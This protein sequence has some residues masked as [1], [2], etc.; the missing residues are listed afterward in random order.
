MRRNSLKPRKLTGTPIR[1]ARARRTAGYVLACRTR[2]ASEP[3]RDGALNIAIP[4]AAIDKTSP[5]EHLAGRTRDDDDHNERTAPAV[6]LAPVANQARFY[7]PAVSCPRIDLETIVV[8]AH[9]SAR[10]LQAPSCA[11]RAVVPEEQSGA[12]E[13]SAHAR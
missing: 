9:E 5:Q 6:A 10:A 3:R 7:L 12:S 2:L 8:R 4:P 11:D 13:Q 1:R